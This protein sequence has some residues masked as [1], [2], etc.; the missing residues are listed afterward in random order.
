ML[1]A[2]RRRFKSPFKAHRN[3]KR[4]ENNGRTSSDRNYSQLERE[5]ER[6]IEKILRFTKRNF[7]S[8]LRL[9]IPPGGERRTYVVRGLK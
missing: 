5:R 3:V 8:G 2:E 7:A 1:I 4:T 6:E 9:S